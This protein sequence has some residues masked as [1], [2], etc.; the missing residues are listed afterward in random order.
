MFFVYC[1]LCCVYKFLEKCKEKKR[2][3]CDEEEDKL[4]MNI[5][6]VNLNNEVV[7]L[8]NEGLFFFLFYN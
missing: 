7:N 1:I 8:K 6:V 3:K 4:L 2:N 5:E